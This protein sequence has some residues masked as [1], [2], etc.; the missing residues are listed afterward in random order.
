[1][2]T[3]QWRRGDH[4]VI[5]ISSFIIIYYISYLN[6]NCRSHECCVMM[7]TSISECQVP[8]AC[9]AQWAV[10]N[11]SGGRDVKGIQ[12]HTTLYSGFLVMHFVKI[13]WYLYECYIPAASAAS[14]CWIWGAWCILPLA[15]LLHTCGFRCLGLMNLGLLMH[16]NCTSSATSYLQYPLPRCEE[17]DVPDGYHCWP[18]CYIPAASAALI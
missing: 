14:V 10:G 9:L 1:M 12:P 17:H 3:L 15:R 11:L 4:C 6:K 18:E 16:T 2:T 5:M 7:M 8:R 13:K